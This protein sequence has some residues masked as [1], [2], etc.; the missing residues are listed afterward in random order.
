MIIADKCTNCGRPLYPGAAFCPVCGSRAF[1]TGDENAAVSIE[2]VFAAK[3]GNPQELEVIN[4]ANERFFAAAGLTA[5]RL[6]GRVLREEEGGVAVNFAHP[7]IAQAAYAAVS[8]AAE[9]RNLAREIIEALPPAI[10]EGAVFRGGVNTYDP[11]TNPFPDKQSPRT[12][13][14]R[15]RTKAADWAVLVSETVKAL[16]G[17][18]F[19]FQAVGFYQSPGG[20]TA[21]KIFE[22]VEKPFSLPGDSGGIPPSKVLI[23]SRVRAAGE[24]FLDRVAAAAGTAGLQVVGPPGS[25]K[26]ALLSLYLAAAKSRG[27]HTAAATFFPAYRHTPFAGWPGICRMLLRSLYPANPLSKSALAAIKEFGARF[28][29]WAPLWLEWLGLEAE[30]NLY[31][32]GAPPRLRR[33][34][35]EA[36]LI[37]LISI[38]L[39]RAPLALF[40]DDFHFA[41]PSS[42]AW[43]G[44]LAQIASPPKGLA[45]IRAA[46]ESTHLRGDDV[47]IALTPIDWRDYIEG[48]SE[49]GEPELPSDTVLFARSHGS[50]WA[51]RQVWPYRKT[52]YAL[53][54]QEEIPGGA[55][56]TALSRRLRTKDRSWRLTVAAAAALGYPFSVGDI[57]N[58]VRAAEQDLS[59]EGEALIAD[60]ITFGLAYHPLGGRESDVFI[61]DAGRA[62]ITALLVTSAIDRHTVRTAAA[63]FTAA[64]KTEDAAL[65]AFLKTSAEDYAVAAKKALIAAKEALDFHAAEEA[66]S[67]LT[68]VI[69]ALHDD[70]G[71]TN[72][73]TKTTRAKLSLGRAEAFLAQGIAAAALADL[74]AA[75]ANGIPDLEPALYTLRGKVFLSREYHE[76]A[77]TAFGQAADSARQLGYIETA[78]QADMALAELTRLKGN[79]A[80]AR[81]FCSSAGL[82]NLSPEGQQGKAELLYRMA[83]IQEA[84]A[85]A[86]VLL[87][88]YSPD[89]RPYSAAAIGLVAAP[90]LF[91]TGRG[92]HAKSLLET[93]LTVFTTADDE[94][95][96]CRT[97]ACLARM[98]AR[99]ERVP[100]AQAAW[101]RLWSRAT[102]AGY[103]ASE[104]DAAIGLSLT[105]LL[106][107]DHKAAYRW[108]ER[109][110][111]LTTTLPRRYQW[112]AEAH[113]A[114]AEYYFD[115][116]TEAWRIIRNTG[117]QFEDHGDYITAGDFYLSAAR[118]GFGIAS[119]SD[120]QGLLNS[121]PLKLRRRESRFFS[122]K[123]VF[124]S[125]LYAHMTGD[126]EAAR[127]YSRAALAAARELGLWRVES[128]ALALLA[129][130]DE[131]AAKREEYRRRARWLAANAGA[132]TLPDLKVTA[133]PPA[134]RA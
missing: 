108:I 114:L 125:G 111:E 39:K 106:T 69:G 97:L 53:P 15:L 104:F 42:R 116:F 60:L 78:A 21:I 63:R 80:T 101:H 126:R 7:G 36:F 22:L 50:P 8:F 49:E 79:L 103:S 59:N 34:W 117:T 68:T 62:A 30:P 88:E 17:G 28:L 31:T 32:E 91:E 120:L 24:D 35:L 134:K 74:D 124:I 12:Q 128:T 48:L 105:A 52:P 84:A 56:L 43:A 129:E 113:R 26:T 127:R 29:P 110:E 86:Q 2:L 13:A 18:Q 66:S 38:A 122:A 118:V 10:K 102:A 130:V 100:D 14:R 96:A 87:E 37:S 27:Y 107:G 115:G 73:I 47:Q 46:A 57:P 81:A 89:L 55:A 72:A 33:Q 131:R 93:A 112:E 119:P 132:E 3:A 51:L 6:N 121:A 4:E 123:Y 98:D 19:D 20:A 58:L 95:N 99:T 1:G 85:V 44:L 41:P 23:P 76:E 70:P 71:A 77:T 25:G 109:A 16:G 75:A 5:E 45:L 65:R 83:R 67:I 82:K 94:E 40:L 11:G 133:Q 64:R 90:I 92:G 54:P 9:I 61:S